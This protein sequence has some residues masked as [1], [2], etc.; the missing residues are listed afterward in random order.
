MTGETLIIRVDAT[1]AMGTGHV[2]R[3]LALAQA[4]RRLGGDVVFA[5]VDTIPALARRLEHEQFTSKLLNCAA[6]GFDDAEALAS[7]AAGVHAAWVAIDGYHFNSAYQHTIKKTG[8]KLLWIDDVGACMPYCA[9]LVLNQNLY[10]APVMY[11]EQSDATNLLLGS[12]YALL[13]EEF[14]GWNNWRRDFRG[15]V[16]RIL[17]TMGGSD[18]Q[19]ATA[20]IL[21]A[22]AR[23]GLDIEIDVVVGGSNPHTETIQQMA[24]QLPCNINVRSDVVNMPDLMA[25]ADL[26]I[27]AAGVTCYE[28]ALLHVPMILITLAE[29]QVPTAKAFAECGAALNLGD[30]ASVDLGRVAEA[31]CA[32]THNAKQRR[33]LAGKARSLVD[34]DGAMRVCQ[35]LLGNADLQSSRAEIAHA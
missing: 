13:R 26:A 5:M 20:Q 15:G 29:N 27:S 18:S 2:M 32:L 25:G 23:T 11:S 4:W 1:A 30:L 6:G 7:V 28:L 33:S 31:V 21:P 24:N 3:C 14:L 9:D 22:L 35:V 19:N 34:A 10:A 12:S 16:K 17:V 8:L